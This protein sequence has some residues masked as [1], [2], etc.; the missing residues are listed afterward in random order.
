[1]I[2]I[3][4]LA[5]HKARPHTNDGVKTLGFIHPTSKKEMFFESEMPE[6]MQQVIEKWKKYSLIK[7]V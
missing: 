5:K 2:Q 1:M 4:W 3:R 7:G 6:D